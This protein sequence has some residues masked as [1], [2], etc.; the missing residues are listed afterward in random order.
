[1]SSGSE[2]DPLFGI[3]IQSGRVVGAL[4]IPDAGA[5]FIE[6]FNNCYG[7]LRMQAAELDSESRNRGVVPKMTFRL[8]TW[9]REAWRPRVDI[10]SQPKAT[11]P[12]PKRNAEGKNERE[13]DSSS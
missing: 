10:V 2:R 1:M 4:C 3:I 7:P 5:D 9:Y 11:S 13:G 8:P 12:T 6:E